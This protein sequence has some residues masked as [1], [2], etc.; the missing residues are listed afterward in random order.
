LK[1]SALLHAVPLSVLIG[2]ISCG[3][4]SKSSTTPPSKLTERVF[5]SQ[6]ASSP[7]AFGG[8][9]IIDGQFDTVGRGGVSTGG[10]PG[11]MAISPNRATLVAFDVLT[12]KVDVVN[13]LKES[14]T[15]SIQLPGIT[16]SI[17]VPQPAVGY[18][19]VPSAPIIGYP[20]GAVVQ[21]NLTGNGI[22]ATIS[23]PGAQTVVSNSTGSQLLAFSNDSDAVTVVTPASLNTSSPVTVSVPGFDRPVYGI[24]NS[25]GSEAYI[26]NCGAECM[27]TQASVQILNL[28]TSPPTAGAAVPVDA[29]TIGLISGTNLYVAGTPAANNPCTGEATAATTCGRL[30]IVNLNSMTVTSKYVITDGYHDRIDMG[31]GGQ[32]FIG[33]HT[34]TNIGNVNNVTGEVRGCLSILNTTNGNIIIPP[35][36]GDVT[37]LQNFTSRQVEYVAEGGNLRVY[38][39]VTDTLLS[40]YYYI[41][42]GTIVLPG[43]IT[44]VKSVDFF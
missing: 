10:A 2:L 19:A 9:V 11:M 28:T 39:T 40:N 34:C 44:D 27:G 30:D 36:N 5:A 43:Y 35:D 41:T 4:G 12:Y 14:E 33:S 8:L 32:L 3:G 29:A 25:D 6:S 13:T 1:K 26:L 18:A 23:V 22:A 20:P 37:G 16:T 24:F 7:S 42:T 15:G 31:Y 38:Y 17:V 21:M